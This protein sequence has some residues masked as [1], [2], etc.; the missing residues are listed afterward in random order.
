MS[1]EISAEIL[2]ISADRKFCEKLKEKYGAVGMYPTEHPNRFQFF[3]QI[4]HFHKYTSCV[5]S[6]SRCI[7]G[8]M[9]IQFLV[10]PNVSW[11]SFGLDRQPCNFYSEYF[12]R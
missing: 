4:Y 8:A 5:S 6:I 10:S 7:L 11:G 9:E 12:H 2:I 1:A 3:C